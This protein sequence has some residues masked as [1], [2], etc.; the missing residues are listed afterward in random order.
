VYAHEA[1]NVSRGNVP[2]S[3]IQFGVGRMVGFWVDQFKALTMS[4][5]RYRNLKWRCRS[6]PRG[7]MEPESP[8]EIRKF[9]TMHVQHVT[10]SLDLW[11]RAL[12]RHM[13]KKKLTAEKQVGPSTSNN[14]PGYSL[15]NLVSSVC[16]IPFSQVPSDCPP[17]GAVMIPEV[18][19]RVPESES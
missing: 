9:S 4:W 8:H 10:C 2:S 14:R 7:W 11:L 15:I 19:L 17:M 18:P 12:T 1:T 5:H 13:K 16:V 6:Q 3:G